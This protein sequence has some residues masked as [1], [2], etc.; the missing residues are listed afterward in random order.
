MSLG[1]N[2]TTIVLT[3]KKDE[4]ELLK[5]FRLISLCSVIYKVVFKCLVNRLRPLLQDIIAPTQST[6]IPGRMIIDNALIAFECLHAI[7]NDNTVVKSMG[8]TSWTSPKRMTE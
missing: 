7:R 5:D 6:F 3:P 4:A 8:P 1:V 2:N